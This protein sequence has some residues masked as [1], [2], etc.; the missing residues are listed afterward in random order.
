MKCSLFQNTAREEISTHTHGFPAHAAVMCACVPEAGLGC[1]CSSQVAMDA[2]QRSMDGAVR[3]QVY[4]ARCLH[5][6]ITLV[7]C[8]DNDGG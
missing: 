1:V 8:S 2:P 3:G 6:H 5:I 4:G 7:S